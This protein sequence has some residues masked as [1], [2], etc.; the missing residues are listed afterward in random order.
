MTTQKDNTKMVWKGLSLL[1]LAAV[2]VTSQGC[3]KKEGCTDP[4]AKNYDADAEKDDG[5]C[6]KDETSTETTFTETVV[7]SDTL[8]TIKDNGEGIGTMTL[9]KSK[10]WILNG[11]VFVNEGQTLTIQA[12]TVIK[13]KSGQGENASALIV[14]RGA[15]INAVG[16]AA[17]PIIFTAESDQLNGNIP[18]YTRGLWGG[19]IV[20]G[21]AKLNS[22]PGETAVEGIPTTEA[23]G[24]YGGSDDTDNSGT[25]K[26]VSIRHGGTDI[27]EGNEI[28]GLTLGGVGS[29]TTIDYLEVIANNDDGIEF[30]G[31]TVG[32]K[33]AVLAFCGDDGFDY[34]EGFRGKGQFWVVIQETNAGDR[35]GEHDGG[36][37][38]EDGSPYAHPKIYNATYVGKGIAGGNHCVTFRD[39]A[40]GEYHN[41]IFVG[42]GK[43]IDVEKL[44][45]G[46]DSYARFGA[47]ELKMVG[48]VFYDVAVAGTGAT[49]SDLFKVTLGS[50]ATDGGAQAAWEASFA[51]NNNS[52]ADPGIVTTLTAGSMLLDLVPSNTLPTGTAPSDSWFTAVQ[53]KG[54]FKKGTTAWIKGWTLIDEDG[55]VK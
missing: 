39:N 3:S 13:G 10:T 35:G 49:A 6:E 55:F 31:G 47:G 8:V 1:F 34:D 2:L 41:S 22:S 24:L 5:S 33:H 28:N 15:K 26:Y 37:D 11:L 40:G 14:A 51:S 54:A 46:E 32:V 30:F 25:I 17:D 36:T 4:T 16:T 43:G 27:G 20:L 29:G 18:T 48:N 42:W 21:K 19:V 44:A 53:Y 50:G 23:R 45:S 52:V 38:P 12:G 9:T 7:G